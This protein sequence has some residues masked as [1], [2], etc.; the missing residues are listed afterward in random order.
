MTPRLL[1]LPLPGRFSAQLF[2]PQRVCLLTAKE[3]F[4]G[5]GA[6]SGRGGGGGGG[7]PMLLHSA[8][9]VWDFFQKMIPV[10]SLALLS[11]GC[12]CVFEC[13]VVY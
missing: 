9:P 2:L 3:V 1:L 6:G 7:F 8:S 13:L 11:V 4:G 12:K 10:L 5:G